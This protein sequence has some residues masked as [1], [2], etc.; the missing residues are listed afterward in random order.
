[1]S[2]YEQRIEIAARVEHAWSVMSDVTRWREWTASITRVEPLGSAP[3]MLGARYRV[4]Q[5]RLQPNVWTVTVLEPPRAFEWVSRTGGLTVVARHT[6]TPSATGC[7][8]ELVVEYSG[9]LAGLVDLLAG[10][11]TRQYMQLE[12]EG[13]KRRSETPR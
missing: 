11:L 1:M 10:R 4:L 8:L 12:A 7:S 2:R 9:F 5:P 6:L 3:L 13:L